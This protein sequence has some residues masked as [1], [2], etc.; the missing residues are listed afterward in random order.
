MTMWRLSAIAPDIAQELE[1]SP[2]AHLRILAERLAKAAIQHHRLDDT[3]ID[4]A[5]RALRE[6]RYGSSRERLD[7][8]TLVDDLDE[9]AWVL[10]ERVEANRAPESDY[11]GA[12]ERARA[13]MALWFALDE[14]PLAAAVEAAYEAEA[15]TD[16]RTL[17]REVAAAG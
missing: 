12:F 9:A 11:I 8:R 5:L 14:D 7:L 1:R 16:D 3:R 15:A 17:R 10:Q 13:A 6:Q 4:A 2:A